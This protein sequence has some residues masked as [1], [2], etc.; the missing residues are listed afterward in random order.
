MEGRR[1]I[2]A[3]IDDITRV[4]KDY[5]GLISIPEDAVPLK[6]YLNPQEQKLGILMESEEWKEGQKVEEMKFDIRRVFSVGN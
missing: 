6:L 4:M 3:S 1:I 2:I 5:C